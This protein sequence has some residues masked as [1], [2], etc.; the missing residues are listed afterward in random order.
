M[1]VLEVYLV[2]EHFNRFMFMKTNI[3]ILPSNLDWDKLSL[4]PITLRELKPM[5][6]SGSVRVALATDPGLRFM[7]ITRHPRLAG[8]GARRTKR[9]F[10][11]VFESGVGWVKIQNEC[12]LW[13]N[14]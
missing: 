9:G 13:L 10:W 6:R 1:G 4:K 8:R 5:L 7:T 2:T 14:P 3:P 12:H 11:E